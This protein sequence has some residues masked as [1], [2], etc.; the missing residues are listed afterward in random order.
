LKKSKK[1]IIERKMNAECGNHR[2]G[3]KERKGKYVVETRHAVS[4]VQDG[5]HIKD[6]SIWTINQR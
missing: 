1:F 2:K 6:A 3:R 4:R 5:H